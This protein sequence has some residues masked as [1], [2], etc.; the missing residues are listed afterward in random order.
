[1]ATT[2]AAAPTGMFS[3][4]PPGH[5]PIFFTPAPNRRCCVSFS[6]LFMVSAVL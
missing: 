5:D 6:Y 4:K 2:A 3:H 1:M